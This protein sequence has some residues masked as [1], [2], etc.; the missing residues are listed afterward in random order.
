MVCKNNIC[1]YDSFYSDQ[2]GGAFDISYYKG[3]PQYGSG[4]ITSFAKRY[5]YPVI[6]YLSKHA[7][8]AGKDILSDISSGTKFSTAAKKAGKKRLGTVITDIGQK[9][10]SGS[11]VRKKTRLIRKKK[12]VAKNK[13]VKKKDKSSKKFIRRKSKKIKRSR[14]KNLKNLSK[15][16]IFT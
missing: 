10:Q 3:H 16:D 5:G 7:Y 8:Q 2:A 6:K 12:K 13:I 4:I 11:G 15:S 1:D 14:K 9:L